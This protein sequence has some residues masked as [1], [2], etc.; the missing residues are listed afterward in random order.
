MMRVVVAF[1][2]LALA[3]AENSMSTMPLFRWSAHRYEK[4]SLRPLR[5]SFRCIDSRHI[6]SEAKSADQALAA[7]LGS[8]KTEI[9][10]VYML[11]EVA[12]SSLPAPCGAATRQ[13]DGP[14][15]PHAVVQASTH[16]MQNRKAEFT[17]L[18]VPDLGLALTPSQPAL[19]SS[20]PPSGPTVLTTAL[21][22]LQDALGKAR[23]SQFTALP[24]AEAQTESLLA[25]ARVNGV[26]G[27]EVEGSKLQV[28]PHHHP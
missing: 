14:A 5:G 27:V 8:G 15:D 6:D 26:Q 11:N 18:E 20:L 10:M 17:H 1:A 16:F 23:S 21:S 19:S 7:V 12:P 13:A 9:A 24:V 3:A 25:T 28:I 22:D 4:P 2:V